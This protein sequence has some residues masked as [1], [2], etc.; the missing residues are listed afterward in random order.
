[1]AASVVITLIDPATNGNAIAAAAACPVVVSPA[2]PHVG[3]ENTYMV[4]CTK[5]HSYK[6]YGFQN[7]TTTT[8]TDGTELSSASGKPLTSGNG[9]AVTVF[10]DGAFAGYAVVV[11]NTDGA[12]TANIGVSR[13]I[14]KRV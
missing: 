9:Y 11:T 8:L 6:V 7:T 10:S 2:D 4:T 13:I 12:Q 1:M 5:S 14:A 3:A